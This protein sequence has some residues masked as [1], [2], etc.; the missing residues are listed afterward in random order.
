MLHAHEIEN[1]IRPFGMRLQTVEVQPVDPASLGNGQNV[2]IEESDRR[3][4]MANV[5]GGKRS[6][7]ISECRVTFSL[8]KMDEDGLYEIDG[9]TCAIVREGLID[10]ASSNP[11]GRVKHWYLDRKRVVSR[12]LSEAFQRAFADFYSHGHA[13]TD[14]QL[15]T[16]I[17]AQFKPGNPLVQ[18]VPRSEIA[19][20]DL[21]SL[22]YVRTPDSGMDLTHRRYNDEMWGR[23]DPASTPGG[24][25]VNIAYRLA[26]GSAISNGA[27]IPSQSMFCPTLEQ[28]A[29]PAAYV[30]R[31]MHIIRSAL[32]ATLPVVDYEYPVIK[33]AKIKGKHLVTAIMNHP[34]YTGEDAIVVSQSAA[35]KMTA[36]RH[37]Q[38]KVF[39]DGDWHLQ[40]EVG[41]AVDSHTPLIEV[42]S[43]NSFNAWKDKIQG[44]Q[45]EERPTDKLEEKGPDRDIVYSRKL[46]YS[47]FV[48][49]ISV[50]ETTHMGVRMK[51]VTIS[52]TADLPLKTGDK[53][54]TRHGVKGIVRVL[55]DDQM[56]VLEDGTTRVELMISPESVI[57]RRAM[58]VYWE[59]MATAY[60]MKTGQPVEADHASPRPTFKQ[61][62]D[63][64]YGK[65]R[66]LYVDGEAL[67]HKTYVGHLFLVRLD[68]LASEVISVPSKTEALTGM[69][70]AL[71]SARINGQKKDPAKNFCLVARGLSN[72]FTEITRQNMTGGHALKEFM[73][74]LDPMRNN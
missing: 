31:R 20:N 3:F 32:C 26:H 16:V 29:L 67:P 47:A 15:Q 51:R 23:L 55:P 35:I 40:V 10:L 64:G 5:S 48:D 2:T 38:E 14:I 43:A 61:L 6:S 37:V 18:P 52:M 60:T 42:I 54:I 17:D 21:K 41:D 56:P 57:N 50:R 24:T 22:V 53:V 36:T 39:V 45:A 49:S 70:T 1:V 12:I 73:K 44:L 68:K 59:M 72:T 28:F 11:G 30:P 74:I 46:P 58:A 34:S 33:R 62:V 27:L 9:F 65:S 8:P 4:F 69:G 66:Q 25:K 63:A 71:N 19:R 7:E 13:P